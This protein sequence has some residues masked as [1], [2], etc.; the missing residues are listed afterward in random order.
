MDTEHEKRPP[1][2]QTRPNNLNLNPEAFQTWLNEHPDDADADDAPAPF[3]NFE[4]GNM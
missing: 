2:A 1:V 4:F 3:E